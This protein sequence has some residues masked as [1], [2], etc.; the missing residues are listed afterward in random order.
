M[1]IYLKWVFAITIILAVYAAY[2]WKHPTKRFRF[3]AR[4]TILFLLFILVP[5]IPLTLFLSAFVI[6][7]R[8]FLM[9]P[10]I[11]STL[12][13][14]LITI[15]SL[16]EKQADFFY[17]RYPDVSKITPGILSSHHISFVG[18]YE[19][20]NGNLI[21]KLSVTT[22]GDSFNF[23]P[24]FNPD[25]FDEIMN[26]KI[27]NIIRYIDQRPYFEVYHPL[28]D[29]LLRVTGFWMQDEIVAARN[30]IVTLQRIYSFRQKIIDPNLIWAF[31]TLFIIVL[32]FIAI[33]AAKKFSQG[34]SEPIR[35]LSN[36]MQKVASGDFSHQI[37]TQAKDEIK[38]LVDSFNKM[39]RDL[40][41]IQEKLVRAER[42]AAWRDIAR[43]VSHEIKNPLTP[44]QLALYQLRTRIKIADPDK[45]K[46]EQSLITIHEELDS[47]RILADEFSQFARMPQPKLEEI[48]L[49]E[50]IQTTILLFDAEPHLVKFKVDLDKNL[51][52]LRLDRE[53]I[54]RVLNN[55]LK[56]GVEASPNGGSI[57]IKT[58]LFSDRNRIVRLCIIDQGEGIAPEELNKVFDPYFS[59]KKGGRGL[60]LPIVKQIIE[61]HNAEIILNS[62]KG[63]GTEV[64][65][66]F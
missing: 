36:G 56:N 31:A 20:R 29:K 44:I 4:L 58:E 23:S 30:Q 43:R 64:Q 9:L 62:Q 25:D 35:E 50:I 19:N 11:E 53:Q 21:E 5:A 17:E 33:Y 10:G 59:K 22:K 34:I 42:L 28:T 6:E 26:S 13:N 46:F 51:P 54:K 7:N 52:K 12:E 16:V 66:L 27:R 24:E 60:G 38:F 32:A 15:R 57:V 1:N 40:L 8:D 18:L 2:I 47:L 3:Q 41:E 55:L 63:I 48:D 37:Q 49:N 39:T 14:S 61:D 65:I 45:E